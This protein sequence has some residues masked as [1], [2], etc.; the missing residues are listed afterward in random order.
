VSGWLLA[1]EWL[2][3]CWLRYTFF[4][5]FR[6]FVFSV[7][8]PPSCTMRRTADFPGLS[9]G[10]PVREKNTFGTIT[11]NPYFFFIMATNLLLDRVGLGLHGYPPASAATEHDN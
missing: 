9:I 2:T 3:D 10:V 11:N 8:F 7:V 4:H 1:A 5:C 6:I